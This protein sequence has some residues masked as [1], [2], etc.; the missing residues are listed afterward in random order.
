MNKIVTWT[1]SS[2]EQIFQENKFLSWTKSCH[3]QNHRMNKSSN[4]QNPLVNKI[5]GWKKSS[6]EQNPVKNNILR[7]TKLSHE[8]NPLVNKFHSSTKSSREQNLRMN[9]SSHEQNRRMNKFLSW[10]KIPSWMNSYWEPSWTNLSRG[11]NP[12][13]N[14]ISMQK[15]VVVK[16]KHRSLKRPINSREFVHLKILFTT[17]IFPCEKKILTWTKSSHEQIFSWTNFS[18]TKSSNEQNPRMRKIVTEPL[19]NRFISWTKT[20]SWTKF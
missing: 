11:K 9:K 2:H 7:W 10:T 5:L 3:E 6:H 1:K 14:N 16:C 20:L 17:R 8:Q 15:K 4:E 12:F 18:W 19:V 13:M